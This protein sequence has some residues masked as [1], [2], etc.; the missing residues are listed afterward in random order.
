[1]QSSIDMFWLANAIF[2]GLPGAILMGAAFLAVYIPVSFTRR[3]DEK[4]SEYR[5][6]YLITMA[7]FALTGWAVHF[8]TASY[9]LFVF[10]LG[11]GVWFLDAERG[12]SAD[13]HQGGQTAPRP[14]RLGHNAKP[15]AGGE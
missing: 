9:V 11:S 7:G 10:L 12:A 2:Y 3:L 14:R 13:I 1:M 6:G 4:V 15:R 5:T 8:W